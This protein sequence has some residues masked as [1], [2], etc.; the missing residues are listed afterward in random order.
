MRI[1]GD[2][3][4][5]VDVHIESRT[6]ILEHTNSIQQFS[7]LTVRHKAAY[8]VGHV[9]NDLCASMWFTYLLLYFNYVREFGPTFAG[10]LL[11][12]GQV[13][14]GLATPF[15]GLESDRD[16]GLWL[17][18]KYGRRKTWHLVGTVA[19][20]C[21]FPFLFAECLWCG[22]ADPWAQ[23]LYYAVLIIVFQFGWASTQVS[24]LSLIP[25]LT[26]FTHERVSLNAV[27]YAF[28]VTANI[29]VY[30]ITLVVLHIQ[31]GAGT[32]QLGPGDA[33][34]FQLIVLTVVGVGTIFSIA[35]HV[36]V[37]DPT[38][39]AAPLTGSAGRDRIGNDAAS[40]ISGFTVERSLHLSWKEWFMESQFYI[41]GLLYMA[42]RLYVNMSQVFIGL[43]L[44][45]ARQLPKESIAIIPLV[46]YVSGFLA[47]FP[48]NRTA[49]RFKL[50]TI[51]G[52][53]AALAVIGSMWIA[54]RD[55]TASFNSFEI[56]IVSVVIGIASTILLI[57]SLAITNE[58][59]GCSTASGAFVFGAMSFLDKLSNGVAVIFIESLH[60][61]NNCFLIKK[62]DFYHYVM[63]YA[64]GGSAV[65]GV[66]ALLILANSK[67]S[68]RRK[69]LMNRTLART[70]V[71]DTDCAQDVLTE[72][73]NLL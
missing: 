34:S 18:V 71:N 6:P 11:L 13:A 67:E 23:F 36:F 16:D 8:A 28:T 38:R 49:A 54:T 48:I 60:T 52:A 72:R 25:D 42:T 15:V 62:E 70:Y 63:V 24:H 68:S 53:G 30:S 5:E 39:T 59:I 29:I 1:N 66:I 73:T 50:R 40:D 26:P 12:V 31:N 46:M 47:S 57:T 2:T 17:C 64:C 61:C 35:F 33:G 55:K 45:E 4:D 14:D 22:S 32:E 27:R 58:L 10:E 7:F 44:Q 43:Y 41:I 56:Y 21:T 19:V 3:D 69:D 37:P 20:I 51:Y 9:L 65:L